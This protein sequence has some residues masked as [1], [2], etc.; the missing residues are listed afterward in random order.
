MSC[1]LKNNRTSSSS[2]LESD[3][4][5]TDSS[6]LSTELLDLLDPTRLDDWGTSPSRDTSSTESEFDEETERSL[7]QRVLLTVNPF[8]R[9]STT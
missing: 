3:V 9:V 5:S 1:T 4:G 7:R 6:P 8:D 2:S